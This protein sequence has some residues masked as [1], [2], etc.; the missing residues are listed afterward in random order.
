[1][2]KVGSPNGDGNIGREVPG[3][4]VNEECG[5]WEYIGYTGLFEFAIVQLAVQDY[6]ESGVR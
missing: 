5:L 2:V 4:S 3:S 1:M 6:D